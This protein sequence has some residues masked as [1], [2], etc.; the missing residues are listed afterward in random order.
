VHLRPKTFQLLLHLLRNRARIVP[1]DELLSAVWRDTAVSEDGVSQCIL[2]LRRILGDD[3]KQPRFIR[4]LPRHGYRFIGQAEEVGQDE[5]SGEPP[6]LESGIAV[7]PPVAPDLENLLPPPSAS[8][9]TARGTMGGRAIGAALVAAGA[10][11]ILWMAVSM[12]DGTGRSAPPGLYGRPTVAVMILT[13]RSQTPE[14]DWMREGLADMLIAGLSRS[15]ALTVLGR[16]QLEIWLARAGRPAGGE[17]ALDQALAV[18]RQARSSHFVLGGFVRLGRRIR[19]DLTV[20]DATGRLAGSETLTVERDE[21]VLTEV[22]LLAWKIAR[23]L[24][25]EPSPSPDAARPLPTTNLEAYRYYSLGLTKANSYQN[26]EAVELF[27]RA[28]ALAPGFTMARARIGYAY[29]VT[30][31]LTEKAKPYLAAAFRA[32]ARLS[33]EERLQIEAWYALANLDYGAAV[34]PLRR[35][36]TLH[37]GQ[38]EAYLTL[39]RLLAGE[40]RQQEALEVLRRGLVVD[41]DSPELH[42]EI[43]RVHSHVGAHAEAV[44]AHLRQVS[45]SPL[46]PKAHDWL[47]LAYQSAGQYEQAVASYQAALEI[48]PAYDP[49]LVHLAN[50]YV[51]M[52]RYADALE[53]YRRYLAIAPSPIERIRATNGLAFVHL[54]RG[55]RAS[56]AG[57]AREEQRLAAEAGLDEPILFASLELERGVPPDDVAARLRERTAV[58]M[59]GARLPERDQYALRGRIALKAGRVDEALTHFRRALQEIPLIWQQDPLE[60]CLAGA[61]LELGR[62]DEAIAEYQRVLRWNPRYPKAHYHLAVAYERSGRMQDA[63]QAYHRFLEVWRNADPDVPEIRRARARLEALANSSGRRSAAAAA[64]QA[65]ASF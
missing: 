13:N 60:D 47:G 3:A 62:L 40:R 6:R 2:E 30:W 24:G 21:D 25:G 50:S 51:Q 41:P 22:D 15:G 63:R 54:A 23:R 35:L 55:A 53:G 32:G 58:S 12:G 59:R 33:E 45:L 37:P 52:G 56:G 11:A 34:G 36:I 44:A 5:A 9:S 4:T 46:D 48:A 18:A 43:G 39:G 61:Y 64:A 42:G 8:G 20:H 19:I 28:L 38:V 7:H 17:V 26:T 27:E 31:I 1:K 57:Y 49:A 14:L 65:D 29:A 10:L 16:Q